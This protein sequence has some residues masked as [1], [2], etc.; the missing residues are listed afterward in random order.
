LRQVARA[1][2]I[3]EELSL[4]LVDV[5]QHVPPAVALN[6]PLDRPGGR[7]CGA[8]R[9]GVEDGYASLPLA[10]Q[11]SYAASCSSV[12]PV[13]HAAFCAGAASACMRNGVHRCVPSAMGGGKY[14][15]R[16]TASARLAIAS[17]VKVAC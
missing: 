8:S 5:V 3:L 9:Q 10:K 7:S 14:L 2:R 17:Y 16:G 1:R 11:R 6:R 12:Q 13:L 15:Q 4:E